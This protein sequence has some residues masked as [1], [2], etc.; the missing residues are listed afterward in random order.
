MGICFLLS[1]ICFFRFCPGSSR[2]MEASTKAEEEEEA[3]IAWRMLTSGLSDEDSETAL[4]MLTSG[5]SDDNSWSSN[6]RVTLLKKKKKKK[7]KKEKK[8]KMETPTAK[9]WRD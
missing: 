4:R 7:K 6:I 9:A 3:G 2:K 1:A 5:W 8:K